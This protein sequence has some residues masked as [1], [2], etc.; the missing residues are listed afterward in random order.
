VKKARSGDCAEFG[1]KRS[2]VQI[3]S[4]RLLFGLV[5]VHFDIGALVACQRPE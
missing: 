2:Q 5:R 3:L 4:P 1:T